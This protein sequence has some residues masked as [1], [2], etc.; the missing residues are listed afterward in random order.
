[1][2]K[3][4]EKKLTKLNEK[5]NNIFTRVKLMKK[6]GKDIEESKRMRGKDGTLGFSEKDSKKIWKNQM[7]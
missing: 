3:K 2:R 6:D 1:M 5:P 7:K 4:A